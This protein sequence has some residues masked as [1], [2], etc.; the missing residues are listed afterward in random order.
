MSREGQGGTKR[1]KKEKEEQGGVW[2]EG[3]RRN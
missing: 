1:S 2:G 3:A